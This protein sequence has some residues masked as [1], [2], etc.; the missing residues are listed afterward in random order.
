MLA[1]L[2]TVLLAVMFFGLTYKNIAHPVAPI[3]QVEISMWWIV[4]IGGGFFF[5]LIV[6]I[7]CVTRGQEKG[8]TG[9]SS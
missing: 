2:V 9:G 7:V 3:D 6:P 5:A 4:G 8:V 1:K